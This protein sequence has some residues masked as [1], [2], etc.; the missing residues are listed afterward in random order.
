MGQISGSR[1]GGSLGRAIVKLRDPSRAGT[2]LGG[3]V[4]Q[5]RAGVTGDKVLIAAVHL[6]RGSNRVEATA[7]KVVFKRWPEVRVPLVL[8]WTSGGVVGWTIST[9]SIISTI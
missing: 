5:D 2:V 3:M 4:D 9:I 6:V 1:A 8:P 7:G